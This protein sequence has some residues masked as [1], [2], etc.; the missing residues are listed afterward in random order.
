MTNTHFETTRNATREVTP[1][2]AL[3]TREAAA[4]LGLATS[5]LNKWRCH[6]GGPHFLKLG[7]AVRYRREDLDAFLT[8]R[9]LTSTASY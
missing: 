6:G 2:V 8:A 5:T 3:T 9:R 4:Y 1:R 7:R